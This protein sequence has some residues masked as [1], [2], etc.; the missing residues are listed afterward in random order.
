MVEVDGGTT[1]IVAQ[2]LNAPAARPETTP[3]DQ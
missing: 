1:V 3:D 2:D